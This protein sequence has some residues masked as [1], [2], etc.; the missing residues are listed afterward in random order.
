MDKANKTKYLKLYL[1]AKSIQSKWNPQIGD[2]CV[3]F[4]GKHSH[5]YTMDYKWFQRIPLHQLK[6]RCLF[7]PDTNWCL[8]QIKLVLNRIHYSAPNNVWFLELTKET[9]NNMGFSHT[10][11][12]ICALVVAEY[13]LSNGKNDLRKLLATGK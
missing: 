13:I 7:I 1:A 6:A 5:I 12:Q 10:D 2:K 9:Y 8:N 4:I 3:Q 11:L